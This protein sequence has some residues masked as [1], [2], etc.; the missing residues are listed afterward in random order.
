V[1]ILGIETSCDET[2]VAVV[3]NGHHL[4]TNTLATS[5]DIH[6]KYGGVVPDKAARE[7]LQ[8]I[9]P[10]LNEALIPL[11][12]HPFTK[13]DALA[14]TYGPGLIGSLLIGVETAKALSFAL[15][16]PLIPVNHLVGHIYA[17]WLTSGVPDLK[18]HQS[19]PSF[20]A[21]V[22]LVS[23]NHSDIVLMKNHGRFD[24][25]GSTKD[26]AAGEC[27]DKCGR[28]LD[29]PYPYGPYIDE[30]ASKFDPQK[31][32]FRLHLPRPLIHSKTL[33][34]SFSGLKTAFLY[35]YQQQKLKT[36]ITDAFKEALAFELQEA[37]TDV[38]IAKFS[39]A[40]FSSKVNSLIL[41]GGVAAN[42]RLRQK[43]QTFGEVNSLPVFIPPTKLC[44]DNAAYIASAAFYNQ[45]TVSWSEINANPALSIAS[46]IS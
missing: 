2:A 43:M 33:D 25:L 21:L 34:F 31:S 19:P 1:T 26:D 23:G 42:K 11:G 6:I 7:Q 18:Y 46:A 20:P 8:S 39:Q 36:G 3:E 32:S 22:L 16:K 38:L 40:T 27:F 14:V 5:L 29:L 28:L 44:T 13:I 30:L 15:G 9:L 12:P 37:I 45:K 24:Y 17:N 41:C 35:L 4:L 10:V